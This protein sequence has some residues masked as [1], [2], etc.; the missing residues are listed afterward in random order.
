MDSRVLLFKKL[1]SFM[2]SHLLI[3]H[4]VA[5]ALVF[6]KVVFMSVTEQQEQGCP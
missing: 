6:R 2:R 4:L 3:V 1:F 5:E